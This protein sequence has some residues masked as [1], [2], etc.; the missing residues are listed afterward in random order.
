VNS[1]A[2]SYFTA[3][4]LAEA[5]RVTARAAQ[6]RA[7]DEGWPYIEEPHRGGQRRRYPLEGLPLDIAAKALRWRAAESAAES[8]ASWTPPS[9]FDYDSEALW[10]EA[11]KRSTKHRN[12]GDFRAQILREVEALMQGEGLPFLKAARHVAARTGR[13]AAAVR[14][15]H[16]GRKVRGTRMR[17]AKDY[18]PADRAAAL[19]P[20]HAESGRQRKEFPGD[21][22]TVFKSLWVNRSEPTVADS[23]R[24]T[25]A[26]AEAEGLDPNAM[27]SLRTVQSRAKEIPP[28]VRVC[29]RE[30]E[31]AAINAVPKLRIDRSGLKVGEAVSGDGLTLD[32]IRA[33]FPDGEVCKPTVWIFQ[34]EKSRCVV[35]CAIGKTEHTS[36][37]HRAL[38]EMCE[39]FIPRR[40]TLDNTRVAANKAM[41]AGAPG[42]KRFRDKPGDPRGLIPRLGIAIHWTDPNRRTINPGAKLCERAFGIGGLHEEVRQHPRIRSIGR[43][44]DDPVPIEQLEAALLEAVQAFNRREGRR[45]RDSAGRSYERS[46][47]EGMADPGNAVRTLNPYQREILKRLPQKARVHG[48]AYEVSVRIAPGEAGLIRYTAKGLLD[49]RGKEVAV[50]FNPDDLDDDA[51]IQDS[52]ER[53]I[54]R[55]ERLPDAIH[56]NTESAGEIQKLKRRE[57]KLSKALLAT[58]GLIGEKQLAQRFSGL[59]IDPLPES[60]VVTADF[61]MPAAQVVA[62]GGAG[63]IDPLAG[64][65]PQMSDEDV[66]RGLEIYEESKRE[67]R[68]KDE[69]IARQDR[70]LLEELERERAARRSAGDA[71]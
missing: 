11:A 30:G 46:Y 41:T 20:R 62:A 33:R 69:Q 67:K 51:L 19:I 42:R 36:V 4:E 29:G 7:Q 40:M 9:D 34:D 63:D 39:K 16:Y 23:Y 6:L 54:C 55:A 1:E 12:E 64:Y 44:K 60:K 47:S 53:E 15:W 48:D 58:Q 38:R 26:L 66:R 49:W 5:L 8:S 50:L 2:G 25:R 3:N 28:A 22:E 57:G 68:E 56:G 17:G 18:A 10:K 65:L 52:E 70:E 24:R 31:R 71:A 32:M 37:F 43:S 27:P 21:M 13:T 14:D 45:D 59:P 35:G 61:D